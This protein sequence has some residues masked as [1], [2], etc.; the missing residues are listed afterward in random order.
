MAEAWEGARLPALAVAQDA[1]GAFRSGRR[2][3]RVTNTSSS[4]ARL[5][6]AKSIDAAKST[7]P[8]APHCRRRS[9]E[10]EMRRVTKRVR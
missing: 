7:S 9:C 5:G 4:R 2:G 10:G 1:V 6:W 8:S 3:V